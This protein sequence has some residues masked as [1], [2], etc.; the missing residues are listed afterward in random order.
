M[1]SDPVNESVKLWR[2]SALEGVALMHA[3]YITRSFPRH[4]HD[5]FAVGVVD[6]GELWLHACLIQMR[7]HS[8]RALPAKGQNI[9]QAT[10]ETGFS[11]QSHLTRLFKRLTGI[12]PGQYKSIH[13]QSVQPE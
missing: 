2:P 1:F 10:A 13:R 9:A 6:K 5:G 7:V 3:T 12:T 8:A 4:V 11:D